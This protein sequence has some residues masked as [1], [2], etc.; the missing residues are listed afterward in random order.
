MCFHL[1]IIL[2]APNEYSSLH[3]QEIPSVCEIRED[4]ILCE[5]LCLVSL[6]LV[7]IIGIVNKQ[8]SEDGKYSY[9]D[10]K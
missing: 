3:T 9:E 7:V 2:L 5:A 1:P 4:S 6:F 10:G 8:N